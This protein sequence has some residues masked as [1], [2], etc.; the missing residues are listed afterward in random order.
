MKLINKTLF[1]I[2]VVTGVFLR[3]F[4]ISARSFWCDEFLA[5]SLARLNLSEMLGFITKS[6]A[7]PPLFYTIVHYIYSF[8][9]SE[10][11][12][13]FIPALFGA[14]AIVIFYLLLRHM[15]Q[16]NYLLPLLLF[17]FSPAAILWSQM[18]KSYSMLTFFSLLSILLFFN[19]GR[20]RKPIYA[21]GWVL[22]ILTTLYLHNYGVIILFAQVFI[23]FLR[24]REF[25]LKIFLLPL[26]VIILAYLPHLSGTV[27][28]QILFVKRAVHTVTNPLLRTAYTFYYFIFGETLSPLHLTFVLPGILLYLTFFISGLFAKRDT[29]HLFSLIV[30]TTSVVMIFF[31]KATIPQNLIHLQPFFFVLV[32]SG[33]DVILKGK[34][35]NIASG[36]LILLLIPSIYYYYRGNSLQYHDASKLVPYRQISELIEKDGKDGE[37]VIFTEPWERRFSEFFE[38]FSPWD[39]YY[40][41]NLPLFEVNPASVKNLHIKLNDIYERYDGYWLLL[42]YGFVEDVWNEEIK[43]FFLGGKSVKI[44]ELKLIKNYSFLDFLKGKE[45]NYYF[46]EVYYIKKAGVK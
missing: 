35:R 2:I 3:F 25:P 6:D 11:G 43:N 24:R 1:I 15:R 44:K 46:L 13:R 9:Q 26:L 45:K 39:W 12:L 17:V 22:S 42:N 34:K 21:L 14:G 16:G 7:H 23:L 31:V 8:T 33:V 5:I 18:V 38:S 41:G 32:A 27:F 10:V 4:H 30:L 19:Y 28:S 37:V 20:T 40:K 36:L 29:L